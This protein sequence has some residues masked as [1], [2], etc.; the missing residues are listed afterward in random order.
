MLH[1]STFR[2]WQT[3]HPK[4]EG[5][6]DCKIKLALCVLSLSQRCFRAT[7]FTNLRTFFDVNK[8]V[9]FLSL[10]FANPSFNFTE[11]NEL[12]NQ[13]SEINTKY[14]LSICA[15][16]KN[17]AKYLNEWIEY[18]RDLGV[19]H[20]YLYNIASRDA[21]RS[22]LRPYIKEGIVSLI[23]WPEA[24]N[25]LDDEVGYRWAFSTLIPA[26][27][28]AVNFI[29]REETKWLMF[30]DVD[31][32]I[33]CAE[34]KV[35]DLL[36]KYDDYSS[37]IIQA[38]EPDPTISSSLAAWKDVAKM[39]FKPDQCEGFSCPPYQ[40][41]LK[42]S[43]TGTVVD[44][45][46]LRINRNQHHERYDESLSLYEDDKEYK[47]SPHHWLQFDAENRSFLEGGYGIGN[48]HLHIYQEVPNFLKK[49]K[50]EQDIEW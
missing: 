44:Q 50:R 21:F 37:I 45:Y 4:A 38:L 49:L 6:N 47:F 9:I 13:S 1:R 28:N 34:G 33:I 30:L 14:T 15:I 11:A 2:D 48:Q 20:F 18:H 29:T 23:N 3:G 19:D 10:I 12:N 27:E 35:T 42:P 17:E 24:I 7:P 25:Q 40:C 46:E 43:Q 22:I 8:I 41:L 16:F 31:E 39:I 26:Y 36:K 5:S 32:Y